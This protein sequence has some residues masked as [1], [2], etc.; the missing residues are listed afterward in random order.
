LFDR[1]QG[2]LSIWNDIRPGQADAFDAW[3]KN[4][5]FPERGP[6][7]AGIVEAAAAPCDQICVALSTLRS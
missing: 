1:E 3:Y 7:L 4:E 6:G 2:V 5:H